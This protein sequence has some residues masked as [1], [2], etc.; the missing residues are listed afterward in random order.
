MRFKVVVVG[1]GGWG[2]GPEDWVVVREEGEDDAQKET[3]CC[4]FW[5]SFVSC[6]VAVGW[7][8]VGGLLGVGPGLDEDST[9]GRQL[10]RS[11]RTRCS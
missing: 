10:E 5:L 11:Q 1:E 4:C 9:Y 6:V 8:E 3:C 2:G 7:V